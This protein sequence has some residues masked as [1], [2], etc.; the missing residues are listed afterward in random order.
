MREGNEERHDETE[1]LGDGHHDMDPLTDPAA[2]DD[3]RNAPTR[4]PT[5]STNGGKAKREMNPDFKDVKETGRWGMIS[6]REILIVSL[7]VV[8]VVV[9]VIVLAVT[10]TSKKD[11]PPLGT[12]S[13]VAFPTMAPSI[14]PTP[15]DQLA[16][17]RN[18]TQ[19]N[20]IL[21]DGTLA[22]LPDNV[23]FYKTY[24]QTAP[25]VQQAMSWLLFNDAAHEPADSIKLIPRFALAVLYFNFGGFNW[26]NTTNWLSGEDICNWH[27][28]SCDRFRERV[29]EIDLSKNNLVG[30]LP[31]ELNFFQNIRSLWLRRNA[32]TGTIPA[33]PI[34]QLPLLTSLYLEENQL[35]GTVSADLRSNGILSTFSILVLDSK[36]CLFS[37]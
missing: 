22:L 35:T 34:G 28:V 15:E 16:V 10:L 1:N 6:K 2:I 31:N 36:L 27:G 25:A 21:V 11:A 29:E 26:A 18:V 37:G 30:T 33:L 23:T 13:P 5:G 12:R 8:A 20:A 32:L 19:F 7:V 9:G 17:I 3:S 14:Q 4:M 24:N